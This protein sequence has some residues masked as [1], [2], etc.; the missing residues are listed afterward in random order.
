MVLMQRIVRGQK[1][2]N[3]ESN[4]MWEMMRKE[5]LETISDFQLLV[6]V[7]SFTKGGNIRS[8]F[9]V[10]FGDIEFEMAVGHAEKTVL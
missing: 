4:K 9:G 1:V 3:L 10:K 7:V 6:E 5:E 8:K 2:Q